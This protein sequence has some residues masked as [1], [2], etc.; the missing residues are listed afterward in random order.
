M[1]VC[2]CMVGRIM[3]NVLMIIF[4]ICFEKIVYISLY[5]LM[6]EYKC[7]FLIYLFLWFVYDE[8]GSRSIIF[9]KF[10]LI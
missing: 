7:N 9:E 8:N 3:C 2:F 1:Y 4:I 10:I 5:R 6:S